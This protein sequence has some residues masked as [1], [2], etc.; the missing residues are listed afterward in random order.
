MGTLH[1]KINTVDGVSRVNSKPQGRLWL[2]K[3]G[4][5]KPTGP[6]AVLRPVCGKDWTE[7]LFIARGDLCGNY[8]QIF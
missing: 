7:A 3:I 1:E 2:L 6:S 5:K 8:L 4:F